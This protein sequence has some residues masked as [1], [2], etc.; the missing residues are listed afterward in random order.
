MQNSRFLACVAAA[1]TSA[2]VAGCSSSGTDASLRVRN[3]SSFSIV[4]IH[5]TTVGSPTWGPNLIGSDL[6]PGDTLTVDVSCA[7]YDALLVD[8]SG[9]QC[10]VHDIDLC[11]SSADWIIRDDTCPVF[12]AARAAREAAGSGSG[13]AQ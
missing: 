10:E 6:Q 7:H 5:V 4:E 12:G 11:F 13:A 8:A 9:V 1:L 2:A 3:D